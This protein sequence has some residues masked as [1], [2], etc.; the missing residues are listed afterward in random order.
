[1]LNS[2]GRTV[3]LSTSTLAEGLS[4]TITINNVA[5]LASNTIA[6]NSQEIFQFSPILLPNGLIGYW[7]FDESS[8][9]IALDLSSNGNDGTVHGSQWT[10][11][12][13]IGGALE[14]DG[15]DDY[16]DIRNI[17]VPGS[18]I[19]IALWFRAEDFEPSD[20][21]LISK[22]TSTSEQDHYWMLSA[23]DGPKLRFRLKA[24]GTT[25]T[26]IANS[27]T[28]ALNTWTHVVATYN[29]SIMNIYK[30]GVLVASRSKSGALD[31]SSAV[32]AWIGRNP[33]SGYGS[34]NGQID[35]VRI[36][37]RA[38]DEDEIAQLVSQP[39]IPTDV[40]APAAP[41]N[42]RVIED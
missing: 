16:V 40:T 4:Y 41:S 29:G 20:V 32:P 28:L 10:S 19:T 39:D 3:T 18:A 11:N 37:D 31:I 1:M 8:G 30:D 38:L 17:D 2:D 24:G 42:L 36:Y 7:S 26:L 14:F 35:E 9:S 5:D 33:T 13:K 25:T 27:P 12:A 34:W 23:I 22:A 21:R 15:T 6:P